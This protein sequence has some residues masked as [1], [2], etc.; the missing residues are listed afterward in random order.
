MLY[1]R[2]ST[3]EPN[4]AA[5]PKPLLPMTLVSD[6]L[7]VPL[8]VLKWMERKYFSP[9]VP[10]ATDIT[11]VTVK[12]ITPD[13]ILFLIHNTTLN[14]QAILSLHKRAQMFHRQFTNRRIKP[15]VISKIY[16]Y[17]GITKK[18][19]KVQNIP[20]RLEERTEEFQ[21]DVI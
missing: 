5:K 21:Q 10:E 17:F 20:A 15:R 14:N 9:K 2:F 7:K 11:K 16:R 8:E 19:V 18:K 1:L 6:L 12:N 4:Q 13:E 3:Y